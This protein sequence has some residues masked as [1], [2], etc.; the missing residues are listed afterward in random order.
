[1]RKKYLYLITTLILLIGVSAIVYYGNTKVIDTKITGN[2]YS[3]FKCSELPDKNDSTSIFNKNLSK[4]LEF[5]KQYSPKIINQDYY[6]QE[7]IKKTH[8]VDLSS[9]NNDN[10]QNLYSEP[11]WLSSGEVFISLQDLEEC[12]NKSQIIVYVSDYSIIDK[13]SN[14]FGSSIDG[15][16]Y[17]VEKR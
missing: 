14:K 2:Y 4:F 17:K 5:K 1:M 10:I 13:F 15:L 6:D 12:Q 8:S 9:I 3:P 16:P 7:G 11:N